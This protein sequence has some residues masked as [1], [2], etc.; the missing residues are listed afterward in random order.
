M[1]KYRVGRGSTI[2]GSF[3]VGRGSTL[4][5]SIGWGEEVLR[6]S[7]SQ[8]TLKLIYSTFLLPPSTRGISCRIN[9]RKGCVP[10]ILIKSLYSD[11]L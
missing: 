2:C 1:W 6:N 11:S 10:I 3:R 7:E 5:G 4:C 8:K 9:A